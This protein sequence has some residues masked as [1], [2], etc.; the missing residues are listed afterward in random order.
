MAAI[1]ARICVAP[2]GGPRKLSRKFV[3]TWHRSTEFLA[4]AFGIPAPNNLALSRIYP[5]RNG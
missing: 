2:A 3:L 1:V 5:F 4:A